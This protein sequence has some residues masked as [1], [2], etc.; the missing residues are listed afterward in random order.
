MD[1]LTGSK[2]AEARKLISQLADPAKRESASQ[3]LIKLGSDSLPPLFEAFQTQD[4][5]LLPVYQQILARIPSAAPALIKTLTTAHPLMRGRAAEVLGMSRDTSAVPALLDAL[6]GEYFTVR[7][8]AALALA[9][10]GDIR[11]IPAL[12]PLLKDQ[13]DEVRSAACA[14]LGK[15][16]E[17]STF[18][19]IAYVLLDDPKIEVRQAAA[20]A[21][22]DT[23][24]PAA[25]PFL[26]EALLDS[27]WWYE[28]EQAASD[29]LA[30]I[31]KMG[32]AAID[33]LLISIEER[34]GTV[35][36][37]SAFLLGRL[38]DPRAVEPLG[39]ALYDLHHEVGKAAAE[40]L[41]KF[42]S[43]GLGPLLEAMHHPEAGIRTNIVRV[44]GII[45][46]PRT[47]SALIELLHDPERS[48]Q[49]LAVQALGG[50]RDPRALEA[51]QGIAANRADRELSL[52][53]RNLI[54][55]RAA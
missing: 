51:L 12:L 30:A 55:R 29:L 54:S 3:E 9:N 52:L 14:A 6:K 35:R 48:I 19:E 21:L 11:V 36:K 2:Q 53:A 18:D 42:G 22:G 44:L 32:A 28:R 27:F 31:E 45:Q 39:M 49:L 16:R 8:R 15:F 7:S 17:P 34:E 43:G 1:W 4:P 38:G 40:S 46:D 5:H 37:F 10:F 47:A 50:L 41:A 24:H 23:K 33:P 20:R 13:E 26:I 25:V